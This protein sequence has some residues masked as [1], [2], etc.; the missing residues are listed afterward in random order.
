[1]KSSICMST[2][3]SKR[4][5]S[6][7]STVTHAP[8]IQMWH[9][10]IR[11]LP[12][13]TRRRDA[14]LACLKCHGDNRQPRGWG[15]GGG[16]S[17][18]SG[19]GPASEQAGRTPKTRRR[20]SL[21]RSCCCSGSCCANHSFPHVNEGIRSL[22]ALEKCNKKLSGECNHLVF[23]RELPVNKSEGNKHLSSSLPLPGFSLSSLFSSRIFA[24]LH[25]LACWPPFW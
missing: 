15:W 6:P 23:P 25:R 14:S 7:R 19:L 1:M 22:Q 11:H 8:E 12:L 20:S 4:R 24:P 9:L 16:P 5:I 18:S 2:G 10:T 21:N 17:D 13:V 3:W